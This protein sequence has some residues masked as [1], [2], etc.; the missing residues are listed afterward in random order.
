MTWNAKTRWTEHEKNTVKRLNKILS[1]GAL[2]ERLGRSVRSIQEV[3]VLLGLTMPQVH[4]SFTHAEDV[5]INRM[6]RDGKSNTEIAIKQ[7]RT[8]NSINGRVNLTRHLR[9]VGLFW[10]ERDVQFLTENYNKPRRWLAGRLG[11]E[12]WSVQSKLERLGLT[13]DKRTRLTTEEKILIEQLADA[14]VPYRQID[15]YLGKCTRS[16]VWRYKK[17]GQQSAVTKGSK[18][19]VIGGMRSN[20]GA[21][22]QSGGV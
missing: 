2:A 13:S 10:T 1:R 5:E 11:R 21:C 9:N 15:I 14:G 6:K 19:V 17:R 12:E 3:R 16:Y 4:R 20:D 7:G 8:L 18:H 22:T